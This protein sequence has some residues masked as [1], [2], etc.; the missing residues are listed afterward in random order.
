[1]RS[2]SRK[3]NKEI[4]EN[5]RESINIKVK[6]LKK[7]KASRNYSHMTKFYQSKF[8]IYGRWAST[9]DHIQNVAKNN[10]QKQTSANKIKTS[11]DLIISNPN[12]SSYSKLSLDLSESNY[13]P[14]KNRQPNK[15]SNNEERSPEELLKI[16]ASQS[17]ILKNKEKGR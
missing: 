8:G 5:L 13:Q 11:T 6:N 4:Q 3:N 1:M 7:S 9:I 14:Y 16:M 10:K 12:I 15:R 17:P 2:K